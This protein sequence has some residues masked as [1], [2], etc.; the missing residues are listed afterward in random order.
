VFNPLAALKGPP[1]AN[2]DGSMSLMEH[3]SS[4]AVNRSVTA[5]RLSGGRWDR[6]WSRALSSMTGRACRSRA[7][8]VP[9]RT[10]P[11]R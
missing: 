5:G 8:P 1:L 4:T 7:R 2:P 3:L 10:L 9:V 6:K 11:T